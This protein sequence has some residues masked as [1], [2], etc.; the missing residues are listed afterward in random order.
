[1]ASKPGEQLLRDPEPADGREPAGHELRASE[2]R[3]RLL[4][5]SVVDYGIFMLD[6]Q[7]RVVSWNIGAER[8][9]GYTA[10]E[11]IGKHFSNFY[12]REEVASGKCERELEIAE[13]VG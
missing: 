10:R 6:L 11:I 4:V 13:R 2:D 8:I 1:M 5:E 7:G 12:S 9:Q 3:M